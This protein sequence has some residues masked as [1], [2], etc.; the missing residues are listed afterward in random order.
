MS[1]KFAQAE[2]IVFTGPN[3]FVGTEDADNLPG[4][5][6]ANQIKGLGAITLVDGKVDSDSFVGTH[7]DDIVS[8]GAEPNTVVGS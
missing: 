4:D 5:N 7:G 2:A 6:P 8:G 1:G 3:E